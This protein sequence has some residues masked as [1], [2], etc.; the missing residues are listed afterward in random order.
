[1][2]AVVPGFLNAARQVARRRAGILVVFALICLPGRARG[3]TLEINGQAYSWDVVGR[4]VM[5]GDTLHLAVHDGGQNAGWAVPAGTLVENGAGG[6]DWVAPEKPGLY[7]L[8]VDVGDEVK[9]VN[10]FV[11]VPIDS[12]RDGM[13]NGYQIGQYP[14]SSH[15]PSFDVP[16]GFI[17]VTSGNIDTR[18]S[19]RHTLREF[20]SRQSWDWPRYMVLREDLVLKL[21]LLTDIVVAKGHPCDQLTVFSGFRTPVVQYGRGSPHSAHVYGGAADLY[22]DADSNGVMDDLNGDGSIS[23]ADAQLLA[24]YVDELEQQHP[25]LVGGCG[26]YRGSKHLGPFIQTDVRGERTRWHR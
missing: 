21:E 11:M 14:D 13:L 1:M 17:E 23:S 7:L 2:S 19:P 6:M 9:K 24:G 18:L 4:F 5:P 15:F 10:A 26:W 8:T 3:F 12:L 22:V 16:R 20:V 25:E